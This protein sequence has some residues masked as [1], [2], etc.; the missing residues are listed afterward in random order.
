VR[1]VARSTVGHC[2]AENTLAI[3]LTATTYTRYYV[4][5]VPNGTGNMQPGT[6]WLNLD[7]GVTLAP[8]LRLRTTTSPTGEWFLRAQPG[9]PIPDEGVIYVMD[10]SVSANAAGGLIPS[11]LGVPLSDS[12]S[13]ANNWLQS[14]NWAGNNS[15]ASNSADRAIVRNNGMPG[16]PDAK[17]LLFWGRLDDR[18][19]SIACDH[20][21][22]LADTISYQSLLDNPRWRIFHNDGLNGKQS[23]GALG[24]KEM[25]GVMGRED[26]HMTPTWWRRINPAN[27]PG[28]TPGDAIPGH[29]PTDAFPL[30]GVF[31]SI[32]DTRP[33]RTANGMGEFWGH[34]GLIAGGN[35]AS[36]MSP[37][38]QIR[39]Y[40]WDYRLE[41]TTPPYFLRAYNASAVFLPGT[42]RT[43]D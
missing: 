22:I 24:F 8:Q 20:K 9:I 34:G 13:G 31:F 30:D 6:N 14:T 7:S 2:F 1:D 4:E 38:F 12:Q 15:V 39:N 29:I 11:M 26:V 3:E 21:I 27:A 18:R 37:T 19:V 23:P 36:G 33:H 35:Y 17:V 41:L 16:D 28:A 32:Y 43:Y 25:L 42:W 40:H 5:R 10:D